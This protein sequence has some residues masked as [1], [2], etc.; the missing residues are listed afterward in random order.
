[1][2]IGYDE[3]LVDHKANV[4]KGLDWMEENIPD[5]L[6]GL[7]IIDLR[8]QIRLDHDRSKSTIAEYDAYD[9]YFY[10]RNKS[11]E[12]VQNFNKAWLH[13]IHRNPHHWQHWVLINDDPGEGEII[14]DMPDEYIIEL[15]CDWWAFS[16]KKEN[17]HEIFKWYDEHKDYMKL[18]KNTRK[19]VEDILS[20]IKS[21]LEE[22]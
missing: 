1:M 15:I 10:G 2:S 22:D 18:S 21:K 13:H 8:N 14:L 6:K 4:A 12:V 19:K 20:K 3:Y 17:L 11:Y 9:Q 7:N 5:I 16:W